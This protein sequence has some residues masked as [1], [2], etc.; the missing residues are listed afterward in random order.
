MLN[1]LCCFSHCLQYMLEFGW[2][3]LTEALCLTAIFCGR[4]MVK[5]QIVLAGEQ[6]QSRMV[7]QRPHYT[8][9][10]LSWAPGRVGWFT[11]INLVRG[12][13]SLIFLLDSHKF[14]WYEVLSKPSWEPPRQAVLISWKSSNLLQLG[15]Y[16]PPQYEASECF[17]FRV[18]VQQKSALRRIL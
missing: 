16:I 17:L 6:T 15:S 18:Q 1:Y 12:Q 11:V 2:N 4:L 7:L 5:R 10:R 13:V 14:N 8:K 3:Q 9:G